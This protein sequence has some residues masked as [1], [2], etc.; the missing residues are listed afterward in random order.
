MN[1]FRDLLMAALIVLAIGLAFGHPENG[2]WTWAAVGGA[3]VVN[4][5]S[6][7]ADMRPWS[8]LALLALALALFMTRL[9]F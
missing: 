8:I 2:N 1:Q 4:A 7:L 5:I 9:K 3:Y 6:F